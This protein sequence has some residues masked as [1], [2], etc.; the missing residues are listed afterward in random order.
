MGRSFSSSVLTVLFFVA[1]VWIVLSLLLQPN[2][3]DGGGGEWKIRPGL[4][5][6]ARIIVFHLNT[7]R[8]LIGGCAQC[9][10]IIPESGSGASGE[11]AGQY[12]S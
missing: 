5:V 1:K 6:N 2:N 10:A 12:E 11:D 9:D 8:F 4:L 3:H 7:F